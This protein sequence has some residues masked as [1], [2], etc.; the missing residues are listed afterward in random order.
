MLESAMQEQ[1]LRKISELSGGEYLELSDL[2]KLPE[3]LKGE[4][5]TTSVSKEI[6]LWDRWYVFALLLLFL[7]I[8]WFVRRQNDAA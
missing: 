2:R 3:L 1:T 5:R 4:V 7:S 8:E 6:S